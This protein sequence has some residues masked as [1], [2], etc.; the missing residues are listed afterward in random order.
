MTDEELQR[1]LNNL[2]VM[3]Q[4]QNDKLSFLKSKCEFLTEKVLEIW[5]SIPEDKKESQ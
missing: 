2:E 1:K 3:I 5:R 4:S